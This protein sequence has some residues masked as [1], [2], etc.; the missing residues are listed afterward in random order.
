MT[1]V[2]IVGS[3]GFIGSNAVAFFQ[4]KGYET[5]GC[6][7]SEHSDDSYYFRVDRFNQDYSAIFEAI[8]FDLCINASG[9]QGVAFSMENP[10]DDFRMNVDNT[11]ALL[12]A[13]RINNPSCRFINLSSAAVYG[14][15]KTLPINETVKLNP[16]SPYGYHKMIAE[17]LVDQ[18]TKVYGLQTCSF[19]IFS[20]Y[21]PGLRKQ[22]FWDI[23]QKSMNTVTGEV[24]LFGTGDETR[25]FVY[26]DDVLNA[27]F[28]VWER[29]LF[30][31]E[32]FNLA[33][34]EETSIREAA[35]IFLNEQ[36]PTLSLTFNAIQKSGDPLYWKADIRKLKQINF[37]T[38]TTLQQG[39][40]L[41][42]QWI[43]QEKK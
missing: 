11:F 30:N 8:K 17:Q 20:A 33:S 28:A 42:S 38:T 6:G 26:I 10:H 36:N 18:F 3:K 31:G 25:D 13:I 39:L 24:Q 21:G 29:N 34:G 40:R 12:N 35:S 32:V 14:N 27:I 22:L 19:R 4:N 15:Q 9:S 37:K 16:L 7:I 1:K 2:L 5:W 23:Y 41:Y 43:S